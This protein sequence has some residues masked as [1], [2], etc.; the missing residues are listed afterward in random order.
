MFDSIHCHLNRCENCRSSVR[1]GEF[2]TTK[3]PD[4]A[5]SGFCAPGVTNHAVSHVVVHPDYV[6]GLYHHDIALLVL[7][8]P[9]NFTGLI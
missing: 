6:S 3:D 2:D 7:R 1:I 8:T 5:E 4:C 9:I